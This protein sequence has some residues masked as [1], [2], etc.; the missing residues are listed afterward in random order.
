MCERRRQGME[1]ML[2]MQ[3]SIDAHSPMQVSPRAHPHQF[4]YALLPHTSYHANAPT[5]GR[6]SRSVS[7]RAARPAPPTPPPPPCQVNLMDAP[8]R[9]FVREGVLSRLK[10]GAKP[11]PY[12]AWLFSDRLLLCRSVGCLGICR[13][14][15][16]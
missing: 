8:A 5:A 9:R 14:V 7:L 12:T 6:A 4:H 1:R 15:G 2:E 10:Q 11:K 13:M 3:A 16:G